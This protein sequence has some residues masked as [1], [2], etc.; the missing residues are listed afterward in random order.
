MCD[1]FEEIEF[2][3][4]VGFDVFGVGE[5]YCLDF[6]VSMFVVVFVVVVVW[7]ECICFMS[8][9]SVISFDELICV[10]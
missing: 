6:V 3:D 10:F 9:V 2:V 4:E 8:V 5:Y 7:I 1:L